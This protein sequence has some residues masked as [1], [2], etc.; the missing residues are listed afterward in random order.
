METTENIRERRTLVRPKDE[1]WLGGVCRGLGAYF[2][3]SPTIYR[4]AF[5]ALAFAGGTGLLLYAAA[6]VVI[7]EEGAADSIAAAELRKHR[8]HPNRLLGLALLAAIGLAVL[9]SIHLWPSPGNFW[10]LAALVVAALAWAR[11]RIVLGIVAALAV[12]LVAGLLLAVRVPVFAGVGDRTYT[13]LHSK[14]TL[15]I[16]K[17]NVDLA[18]EQLPKG[19]TFVKA[20][21]GIGD[22]HVVVPADATVDVDAHVQAGNVAALG[23]TDDGTHVHTTVVDRTGSGRVLVLD[24]HTGL[25]KITVERG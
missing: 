4:I 12:T 10:V 5:A 17:L 20:T 11:G 21:L 6:W 18:G 15:G 8:D 13:D 23:R 19:Q 7:P 22:L 2:D 9:S 14:Y 3:L 24:L 1:R 16:G 25:G